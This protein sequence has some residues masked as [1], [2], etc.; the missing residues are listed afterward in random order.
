MPGYTWAHLIVKTAEPRR[1]CL[2]SDARFLHG[3]DH[4]SALLLSSLNMTDDA[5]PS[6]QARHDSNDVTVDSPTPASRLMLPIGKVD[7]MNPLQIGG[8][9]PGAQVSS[10]AGGPRTS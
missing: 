7:H 2:D 8:A 10:L 9:L 3:D 1:P 4:P 6:E 5:T